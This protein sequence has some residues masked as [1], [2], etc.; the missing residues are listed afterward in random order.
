M[1]EATDLHWDRLI[2][3]GAIVPE[4]FRWDK[5][6]SQV[7]AQNVIND[8]GRRD[9]WPVMAKLLTYGYGDAG[10]YGFT[11]GATNRFH[12]ASHGDYFEGDFPN[13]FW[14][15]WIHS[16]RFVEPDIEASES[17]IPGWLGIKGL[18]VIGF[19][20]VRLV[21]VILSGLVLGLPLA[22]WTRTWW[23]VYLLAGT[24]SF[25]IAYFLPRWW[26]R[27]GGVALV[28]GLTIGTRLCLGLSSF[29]VNPD[30]FSELR[31][32]GSWDADNRLGLELNGVPDEVAL[33]PNRLRVDVMQNE[34]EKMMIRSDKRP[35][36]PK[37]ETLPGVVK[38]LRKDTPVGVRLRVSDPNG[39]MIY[40]K[41][42]P[43]EIQGAK[44]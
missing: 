24:V 9:V 34:N 13:K 39:V 2:F 23:P 25:G 10:T 3:C 38:G 32:A 37:L 1:E 44:P 21:L 35:T 20:V 19:N 22:V 28:V 26:Y 33:A 8:V 14:A 30:S 6:R 12:N 4:D 43:I 36:I 16:G 31:A 40:E 18:N 42:I 29:H 15:P 5:V 11:S 41:Q 17:A 7:D 27:L